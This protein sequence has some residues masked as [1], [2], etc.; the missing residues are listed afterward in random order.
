MEYE[1]LLSPIKIGS[2]TLRNRVVMGAMGNAVANED[3]TLGEGARAYYAER[4][5]GGVG[6]IINEATRVTDEPHGVMQP[7][8][9]SVASDCLLPTLRKTAE[10]VH[11]YGGAIF[12]QLHHPGRQGFAPNP[13]KYTPSGI[14]SYLGPPNPEPCH[15]MSKEEIQKLVGQFVD[16]A[17]RCYKAGIDGVELHGAHGYLIGQFFS[18]FTNR[19]TDEYGGST[20]NRARFAK[21]IIQGIR[22]R[23]G[24][25]YPVMLR[26]SADEFLD[27]A[28]VPVPEAELGLKVEEA[29][30]ICQHLVP[31]GL[32]AIDVSAG[33][34]ESMNEAWEPISYP[35]GWKLYLAEEIKK[36]VDVPVFGVGVI[37]NPD[38]AEKVI[39][40]GRVDGVTIA[41]GLL[42]DPEWINKVKEGRTRDIRRC[43]SCLNC[44]STMV[45]NGD[46]GFGIS[47][48]VN[49][50]N[51][52]E[53]FYNDLKRNGNGRRC[54]VIG[55]GPA[56]LEAARI[57][58]ERGFKVTLFESGERIGGQ[59]NLALKAPHKEKMQWLIEYYETQL[60]QL[61]VEIRLKT[62]AGVEDIR[63]LHPYAVFVATGSKP[64]IPKG[65]EGIGGQNVYTPEQVLGGAADLHNKHVVVIGSGMTGLETAEF[66]AD[67]GNRVS[68][69][70]MADTIAPGA[71]VQNVM[72]I[73]KHID[74][75]GTAYYP[76]HKLVKIVE[77]GVLLEEN[78]VGVR[79]LEADAV[80]ISLGVRS[81]N[82]LWTEC[83]DAFERTVLIG[84][85]AQTGKIQTAVESG[86]SEAYRLN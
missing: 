44:M 74:A 17:E 8:Q 85:A 11:F 37:R 19:R 12:F 56:G 83:K 61:D 75:K 3:Q 48:S 5:K 70:E 60:T 68:I 77:E 36:A 58:A 35:E 47:C 24:K 54:V 1:H 18:P 52:K 71:S 25:E 50:R 79:K 59:V 20:E 39:A 86:F 16:G 7:R 76:G 62:K 57:L 72:D 55:G 81:E 51:A 15:T 80:V 49:A 30:K 43:I 22:E 82:K 4:A 46:K 28:M 78:G 9:S 42:A 31:F 26:I 23:L 33:V 32:D 2:L 65:I 13:Q 27:R 45:P 40:E 34:Y 14:P 69:V 29:V 10:A 73:R 38:F 63:V 66:L 41:R 53:W 64:V 21:E 67:R 6:L 84:D